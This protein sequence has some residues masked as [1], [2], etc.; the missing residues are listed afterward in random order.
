MLKFKGL[1]H[2][3]TDPLA[4]KCVAHFACQRL[5]LRN[6]CAPNS[7]HDINAAALLTKIINHSVSQQTLLNPTNTLINAPVNH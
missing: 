7:T 2:T 3:D 4:G 1:W 6:R 5:L